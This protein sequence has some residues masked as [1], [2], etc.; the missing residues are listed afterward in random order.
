MKL[1]CIYRLHVRTDAF[2]S[3]FS[4]VCSSMKAVLKRPLITTVHKRETLFFMGF[5][6]KCAGILSNAENTYNGNE[7]NTFES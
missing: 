2:F 7:I 1:P 6:S 5:K 4:Y 3:V